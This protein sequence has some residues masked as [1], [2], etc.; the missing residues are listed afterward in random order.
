[1][2]NLKDYFSHEFDRLFHIES[3]DEE[4]LRELDILIELMKKCLLIKNQTI[5]DEAFNALSNNPMSLKDKLSE[6]DK[7]LKKQ[8]VLLY[9]L[10]IHKIDE[11]KL[12]QKIDQY[13]KIDGARQDVYSFVQDK[14]LKEIDEKNNSSKT[15]SKGK[16]LKK[17]TKRLI[18]R[19][20][21]KK[22][23]KKKGTNKKRK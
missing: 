8:D 2:D 7:M 16:G 22:S 9:I 23:R 19:R 3:N 13:L 18:R 10:S 4:I 6:I 12:S 21:N 17:K 20:T 15:T 14:I 11:G 1:M 5:C